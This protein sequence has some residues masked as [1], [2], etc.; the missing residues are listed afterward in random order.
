MKSLNNAAL[1]REAELQRLEACL[2]ADK[3]LPI[4]GQSEETSAAQAGASSDETPSRSAD[5]D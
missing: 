4:K 1:I 3:A 5:L 2:A